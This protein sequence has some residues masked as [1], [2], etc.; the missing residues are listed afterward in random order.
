M[1]V[2]L[3]VP[4][5]RHEEFTVATRTR[6][7]RSPL[8]LNRPA[9]MVM[10]QSSGCRRSRTRSAHSSAAAS[11]GPQQVTNAVAMRSYRPLKTTLLSWSLTT[12]AVPTASTWDQPSDLATAGVGTMWSST[13]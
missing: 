1:E 13:R 6:L 3:D 4:S 10:Q 11:V 9:R 2:L 7:A 12:C 5:R 8:P